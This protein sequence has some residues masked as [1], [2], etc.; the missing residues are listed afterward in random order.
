LLRNTIASM[1]AVNIDPGSVIQAAILPTS[2]S[3]PD[4]ILNGGLGLLVGLAMGIGLAFLRERLDDR[5]K[6]RGD[7]EEH[8]A[9]P[10]LVVIPKIADWKKKSKAKLVTLEDPRGSG[11]EAYKML[12]TS[13]LFIC[14]QNDLRSLMITSAVAG[15]GKTTTAANL[16]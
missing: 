5:L 16:A 4:H 6:G 12:R 7:L 11:T 8:I 1:N 14:A 3:S 9:A 2:P 13:I 15:E 10:T